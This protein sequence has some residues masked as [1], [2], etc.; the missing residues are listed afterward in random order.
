MFI[1]FGWQ[2]EAQNFTQF[3]AC[4]CY[5]CAD[6][7]QWILYVETEWVSFFGIKTIPFLTKRNVY[8]E[9]CGDILDFPNRQYLAIKNNPESIA[10]YIENSQL[11][12]KTEI[13]RKYLIEKRQETHK[14]DQ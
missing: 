4:Y 14:R 8:C 13:Q 9:R 5:N 3:N 1:I 2:K 6:I 11:A 7:K 12:K 10:H